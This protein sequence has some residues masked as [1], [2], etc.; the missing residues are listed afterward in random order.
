MLPCRVSIDELNH[1]RSQVEVSYEKQIECFDELKAKLPP[2]DR[3]EFVSEMGKELIDAINS[4]D[5]Q[6]VGWLIVSKDK[7]YWANCEW[8]WMTRGN[9]QWRG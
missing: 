3:L 2:S 1:D 6:L 4:K 7:D 5:L 9:W 8:L